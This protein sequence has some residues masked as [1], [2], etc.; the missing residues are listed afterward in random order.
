[1]TTKE[2]EK[3]QRDK[4]VGTG[5]DGFILLDAEDNDMMEEPHC[6]KR[7]C[8]HFIGFRDPTDKGVEGTQPFCAAFPKGIPDDIA[9][10]KS[11]HLE[12]VKGD[13][14]IQ[15]EKEKTMALS[16]LKKVDLREEWQHEASDFTTW[17][18][19]D[20]NLQLLSEEIGIDIS[21]IQTEAS[22]G[23]FSVD[24]LAEE[25]NT[26]R[27]IVI[28][29]QLE[30]TNHDHLGKIITYASGFDA[31]I[32]IW[33]VKD[34]RDEHKQAVDWLNEHT[35]PKINIFAIRME[36]WQI[37]DSPF[38][39]KFHVVSQP[40][41]WAKAIKVLPPQS[42]LSDRRLM[43]L[44]FWTRFKE[45]ATS[46][47]SSLRLRKAHPRHWYD[48]SIG[49]SNSHV[50]L[51]VDAGNE[52]IRCGL[53]IPNSKPLFKALRGAKDTIE[54]KLKHELEWMELEGKKAS[55]VR[56]VHSIDAGSSEN[57]EACFQ[58]LMDTAQEFQIVFT[59]QMKKMKI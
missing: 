12:P 45:Y 4:F 36:L 10:G 41:D 7:D 5:L 59:D 46:H 15:F 28:E 57:W 34:V 40:N 44:E 37:G 25:E 33:I 29:N 8:M 58:W 35:D 3:R 24:I 20:E 9:W 32:L 21:L 16:K 51:V 52:Q 56:T 39:P 13:H 17:L 26:G 27:K 18:A 49:N 22:V 43:Q 47:Q 1:M 48:I 50:S 2:E 38:A 42:D 11:L 6:S 14:G 54:A 23:K 31:E 53:Y 55:R 19:Q 30:T